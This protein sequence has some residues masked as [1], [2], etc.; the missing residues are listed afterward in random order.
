MDNTGK[1][2]LVCFESCLLSESLL[3]LPIREI[4][5]SNAVLNAIRTIDQEEPLDIVEGIETGS[6]LFSPVSG[7]AL[8]K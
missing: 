4:E 1:H 3:A 8:K 2:S 7:P 5:Y 6:L